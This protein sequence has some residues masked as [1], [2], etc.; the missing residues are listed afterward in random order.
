MIMK[1]HISS[2]P[3]PTACVI[4]LFTSSIVYRGGNRICFKHPLHKVCQCLVIAIFCHFM[5]VLSVQDC[6]I[7][8]INI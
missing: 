6:D 2:T 4:L 7:A 8:F 1:F 5:D 3:F